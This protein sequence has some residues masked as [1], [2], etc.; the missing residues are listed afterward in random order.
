MK[1]L[2]ILILINLSANLFAQSPIGFIEVRVNS[3][4]LYSIRLLKEGLI[5]RS[6]EVVA[7]GKWENKTELFPYSQLDV[8]KIREI[9]KF[10]I[11]NDFLN[12][13][14]FDPPDSVVYSD[15]DIIKL[16]FD[17][18]DDS[19]YHYFIYTSCEPKVDLFIKMI[20]DLVPKNY[21]SYFHMIPK[22]N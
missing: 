5:C 17:A 20:N 7:N 2:L 16:T 10:I 4:P 12:K 22:C 13:T 6:T 9:Q 14:S 18:I 21:S 1:I 15:H 19:I 8:N 11:E 3:G